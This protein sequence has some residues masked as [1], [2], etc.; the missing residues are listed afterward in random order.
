VP[1]KLENGTSSFSDMTRRELIENIHKNLGGDVTK[2]QIALV[3]EQ[4]FE[5]ITTALKE[6]GRFV[7]P[8][9][10]SFNLKIRS[11]RMMLDPQTG[12]Q[13]QLPQS[14]NITFK[15]SPHLKEAVQDE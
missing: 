7:Q 2:R 12:E 11:A 6:E 9:F 3:A 15:P 1:K 4:V 14:L 13:R 8:G 10:G 5:Q